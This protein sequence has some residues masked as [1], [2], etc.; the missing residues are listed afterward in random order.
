MG[1]AST[2]RPPY[3][4]LPSLHQR[5]TRCRSGFEQPSEARPCLGVELGH[6]PSKARAAASTV[7]PIAA[8]NSVTTASR[9]PSQHN[10]DRPPR[11]ISA[12]P[13]QR[14]RRTD[15]RLHILDQNRLF[16]GQIIQQREPAHLLNFFL[17]LGLLDL[18]VDW[19]GH[20]QI[21]LGERGLTV[22]RPQSIRNK[23][24]PNASAC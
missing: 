19:I 14:A 23:N 3:C 24:M 21:S 9:H 6:L 4:I 16:L 18:R 5:Q 22:L 17:K 12:S 2:R 15:T 7:A 13:K 8:S 1:R 20:R 11:A 10:L